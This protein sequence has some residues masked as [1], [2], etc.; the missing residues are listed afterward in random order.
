MKQ[1]DWNALEPYRPL[2][3]RDDRYVT[4]PW[5]GGDHLALLVRHGLTPIA[6]T[7]PVGS[8]K[9]TEL[10]RALGC[11]RDEVIAIE[12]P[13]EILVDLDAVRPDLLVYLVAQYVLDKVLE[14]DPDLVPSKALVADIRASDPRLPRGGGLHHDPPVLAEL[15]IAEVKKLRRKDRVALFLDG[16]DRVS[17]E[18]ARAAVRA[19]LSLRYAAD[20]VVVVPPALAN[21]PKAHE[22]LAHMRVFWVPTVP[23]G[24]EDGR[25]Y[26]GRVAAR[27]LGLKRLSGGMRDLCE[28]AAEE[29]GGVTR[30]FLHLVQDAAFYAIASGRAR[31]DLAALERAVHDHT[32]ALRRV[33]V[34]GDLEALR[35]ADGTDGLDVPVERK[36]RLLAHNLL[37]EYEDTEG[38]VVRPHPLVRRLIARREGRDPR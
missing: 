27:R 35:A 32:D 14:D 24:T 28:R 19:L 34:A 29:S 10:H 2:P 15:V 1:L 26:L 31:P 38:T 23:V 33:L 9:T 18:A 30:L 6:V 4:R 36:V 25:R 11:L 5:G 13:V 8:G 12:I 17:A 37:L 22:V 7:G 3:G 16:L 21:G 20:L